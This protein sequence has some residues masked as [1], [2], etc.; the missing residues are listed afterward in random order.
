M[1]RK[2]NESANE[3]SIAVT[4]A[5]DRSASAGSR[6]KRFLVAGL[7]LILAAAAA[8]VWFGR[9]S[10]P[11]PSLP[12]ISLEGAEPAVVAAIKAAMEQV[13]QH[14]ESAEDWGR[15]GEVLQVH[16]YKGP[17]D[18]CYAE[19]ERLDPGDPR[20]PYFRGV[21]RALETPAEAIPFFQKAA[22]LAPPETEQRTTA[23][24]QWAELLLTQGRID[25]AEQ[26]LNETLQEGQGRNARLQY[27]LG[28]LKVARGEWQASHAHFLACAQS[29]FAR[30]K[31]CTQMAFVFRHLGEMDAARQ[32]AAQAVR[33]P[34]D[35]DWADPYKA[36]YQKL[37]ATSLSRN[38]AADRLEQ[39]GQL[40]EAL[41]IRRD[42]AS[43]V[44]DAR[45]YLALGWLLSRLGKHD[46]AR[47]ALEK[48]IKLDPQQPQAHFYLS[49]AL[50]A[51]AEALEADKRQ[52]EKALDRY[53]QAAAAAQRA[54]ELRPD[55]GA[56]YLYEGWALERLSRLDEA[57]EAFRVAA[58]CRPEI[59]D[60]HL[61]LGEALAKDGRTAEAIEQLEQADRVSVPNDHR[62]KDALARLREN[63]K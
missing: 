46:E 47:T 25:E 11:A 52:Q 21:H 38:T 6:R 7:L 29:P 2:R 45:S 43:R 48:A 60:T 41:E 31:A 34:A 23:E 5:E 62:A 1:S 53:R 19:A 12:V 49:R 42:Q 36:E 18:V 17:S 20:W 37:A 8:G 39:Q 26:V 10:P 59:A 16:A 24:L 61:S 33:F 51:E 35:Q 27:D 63:H 28:L 9:K 58:K 50:F 32:L 57:I 3:S 15:L 30:K 55:H 40:R 56:A 22:E 4:D 14:P 54:T 13:R 44:G